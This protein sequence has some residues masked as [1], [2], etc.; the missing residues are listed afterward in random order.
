MDIKNY[1][2]VEGFHSLGFFKETYLDI[3]WLMC[4][5]PRMQDLLK[6]KKDIDT[7]LDENKSVAI[8]VWDEDIMFPDYPEFTKLLNCYSDS[9]V[10]LITQ[11]DDISQDIYRSYHDITCKLLELPWWWLNDALCY[12]NVCHP[13]LTKFESVHSYLCM[14]GRVDQ[15]KLNL[16][17]ALEHYQVD[18]CGL[19][20]LS[21]SIDE[22]K[23][24]KFITIN[25]HPPYQNLHT[26]YHKTAAQVNVNNTWISSNVENFLYI[27]ETYKDIPLVVHSETTNGLFFSTEK[28][29]WPL[30]LGKMALIHGR[31]GVMK[32][33][34][35]F[36][37][38]NISQYANVEFDN[39]NEYDEDSH[40]TRLYKL[41]ESN[42]DLI[43]N[44]SSYYRSFKFELENARWTIGENLLNFCT[45]QI[46]KITHKDYV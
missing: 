3:S 11:L 44:S 1:Q 27:E 21:E 22:F 31:P 40:R 23:N 39:I 41:I 30:L 33:A 15:N 45:E 20:T 18:S 14:V 12:Y 43:K 34:Q 13:D 36:Y 17:K 6:L 8:V 5:E 9:P 7:A 25:K 26:S 46:K 32:Y 37:D 4:L 10:W 28:S 24:N 2:I 38:F 42:I 29:L 16:L 19:I 35:R